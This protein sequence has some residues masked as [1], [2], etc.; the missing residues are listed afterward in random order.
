MYIF[1]IK[2]QSHT[3]DVQIKVF[4]YEVLEVIYCFSIHNI[5]WKVVSCINYS[6]SKKLMVLDSIS[7]NFV[8]LVFVASCEWK[9]GRR[10]QAFCSIRIVKVMC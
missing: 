7:S 6:V 4:V 2:I 1:L 10:Q 5:T 3:L 8:Q 9:Y